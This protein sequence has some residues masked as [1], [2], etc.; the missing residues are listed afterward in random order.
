MKIF[1]YQ[2][3]RAIILHVGLAYCCNKLGWLTLL[4]FILHFGLQ[5]SLLCDLEQS[6]DS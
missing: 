1:Q 2:R 5:L 6:L 3:K 4:Y